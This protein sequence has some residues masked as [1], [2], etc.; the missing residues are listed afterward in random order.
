MVGE[1]SEEGFPALTLE[2]E[3]LGGV[4]AMHAC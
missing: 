3:A 1:R 2:S 4:E